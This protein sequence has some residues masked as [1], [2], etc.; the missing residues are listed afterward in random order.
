MK[1]VANGASGGRAQTCA[2]RGGKY[3]KDHQTRSSLA[4]WSILRLIF[5]T[6]RKV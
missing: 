4:A 1:I 2:V 6:S 5:M 3:S